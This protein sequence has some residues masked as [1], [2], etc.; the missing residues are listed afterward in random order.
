MQCPHCRREMTSGNRV[1]HHCGKR[2]PVIP[3]EPSRLGFALLLLAAL[4]LAAAVILMVLK[5]VGL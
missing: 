1:C 2:R 5:A 3:M 4:A